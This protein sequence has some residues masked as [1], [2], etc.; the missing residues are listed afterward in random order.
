MQEDHGEITNRDIVISIG[1]VEN[2]I[3]VS[4]EL[5]VMNI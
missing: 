1:G 4:A 5:L 2:C 3:A